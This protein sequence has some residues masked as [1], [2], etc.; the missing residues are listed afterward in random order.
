MVGKKAS[1]SRK[2]LPE[3]LEIVKGQ[4]VMVIS[5][6][7]TDLDVANGARGTIVDILLHPDEPAVPPQEPVVTLTHMPTCILVNSNRTRAARLPHLEENVLPIL[8]AK[9]S[10]S[11]VDTEAPKTKKGNSPRRTVQR[12]QYAMTAAYN[13][14]DYRSQGQTISHVLVDT[15]NPP[16]LAKLT[17][18]NLYVALSR[19]SGRET[20]RLLRDFKD[21]MFQQTHETELLEED[22]WLEELDRM[23]TKWWRD[24]GRNMREQ[25]LY[26]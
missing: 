21:G 17:L 24:M 9:Q 26:G 11:F 16:P 15:Q 4:K 25:D 2:D 10:M 3:E 7:E 19:S 13:F 5:N 8:P 18:F 20:I 22:D 1:G 12:A 23:T 6:L 14:T